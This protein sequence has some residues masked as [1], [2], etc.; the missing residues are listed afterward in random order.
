MPLDVC[1]VEMLLE[2]GSDDGTNDWHLPAGHTGIMQQDQKFAHHVEY[3]HDFS[4]LLTPTGNKLTIRHTYPQQIALAQHVSTNKVYA[5]LKNRKWAMC[6]TSLYAANKTWT[7]DNCSQQCTLTSGYQ[8]NDLKHK[9]QDFL[10]HSATP[11]GKRR[12]K[13]L[14][15]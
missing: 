8:Q 15:I 12:K 10:E 11:T 5:W 6:F 1:G 14:M 13:L 2:E 9:C 7:H 3:V 4:I